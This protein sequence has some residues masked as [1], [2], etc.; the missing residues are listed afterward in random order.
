MGQSSIGQ[1]SIG[2]S[3]IVS[4]QFSTPVHLPWPACPRRSDLSEN[5]LSGAIPPGIGA[6]TA[7]RELGLSDNQLSGDIPLAI[8]ALTSL[9]YL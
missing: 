7:L 2:Q 4:C 6:L 1:S 8:G 5:Q 3:S 9:S